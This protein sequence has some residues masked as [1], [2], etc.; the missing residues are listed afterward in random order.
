MPATAAAGENEAVDDAAHT[1]SIERN[2]GYMTRAD[3]SQPDRSASRA[4]I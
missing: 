2:D 1:S 3:R 4:A